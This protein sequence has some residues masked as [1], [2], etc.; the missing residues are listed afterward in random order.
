MKYFQGG[1]ALASGGPLSCRS[2]RTEVPPHSDLRDGGYNYPRTSYNGGPTMIHMEVRKFRGPLLRRTSRRGAMSTRI[3]APQPETY[4]IFTHQLSSSTFKTT[5]TLS[6]YSIG[7]VSDCFTP[8]IVQPQNTLNPSH[9]TA[10]RLYH[11][12][13]QYDQSCRKSL[14]PFPRTCLH[15]PTNEISTEQ[16]RQ[17][18]TPSSSSPHRR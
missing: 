16:S 5:K 9:E 1:R 10:T 8:L 6:A 3:D 12:Q 4:I 7:G 14:T 13:P 17:N 2:S 11:F 15:I 18:P